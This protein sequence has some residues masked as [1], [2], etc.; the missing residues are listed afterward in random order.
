MTAIAEALT[1]GVFFRCYWHVTMMSCEYQ[2]HSLLRVHV[3]LSFGHIV[4]HN[5][6]VLNSTSRPQRLQYD[7]EVLQWGLNLHLL[8]FLSL[9]TLGRSRGRYSEVFLSFF[10]DDKTSAPDVFSCCSFIPHAH[11][12]ASLVM[13]SYYGYEIR[14]H[15]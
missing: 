7:T 12:E 13:V 15:K 9:L 11:F 1:S 4:A 6:E 2:A 5:K 14:R 3:F 8:T 10:L